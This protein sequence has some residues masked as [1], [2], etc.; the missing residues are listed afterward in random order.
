MFPISAVIDAFQQILPTGV[1]YD[2]LVVKFSSFIAASLRL[3]SRIPMKENSC[4]V[5]ALNGGVDF[6][7]TGARLDSPRRQ[8]FL[9]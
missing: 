8:Y 4:R 7:I 3:T 9:C 6:K 5:K 1:F 2:I